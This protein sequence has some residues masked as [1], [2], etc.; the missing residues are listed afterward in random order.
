MR[1]KLPIGGRPYYIISMWAT[2]LRI[3]RERKTVE[4]MTRI[5][6]RN[7]HRHDLCNECIELL[8][9]AGKR[10][11]K[12]PYGERKPACAE[13]PIHCYKTEMRERIRAVM[14]H[15]G[16]RMV[17]RHPVLAVL[18]LVDSR[19]KVSIASIPKARGK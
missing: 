10:L 13:C 14:R 1:K 5:F 8:I 15:A 11:D 16:P 6:C 3:E 7:R 12:C 2:H 18:H 17:L 4:A 19:R 9:Y